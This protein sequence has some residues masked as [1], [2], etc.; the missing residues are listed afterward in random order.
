MQ[1]QKR[2]KPVFAI[3]MLSIS[4]AATVIPS[5]LAF[6]LLIFMIFFAVSYDGSFLS[7]FTGLAIFTA[8]MSIGTVVVAVFII[9]QVA[10]I[11]ACAIMLQ[12]RK[13]KAF[14]AL[15]GII[16]AIKAAD[17]AKNGFSSIAAG[18]SADYGTDIMRGFLYLL[19]AGLYVVCVVYAFKSE[20]L[21][22]YFGEYDM[23]VMPVQ[24]YA[25]PA[26]QYGVPMPP[27][28]PAQQ[29]YYHNGQYPYVPYAPP[30]PTVQQQSMYYAGQQYGAQQGQWAQ[31]PYAAPA[32][33]PSPPIPPQYPQY[34]VPQYPQV[35]AAPQTEED[36]GSNMQ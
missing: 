28:A 31:S 25:P 36:G 4:A 26:G 21:K 20:K 5:L 6:A 18:I 16:Y 9:A 23:L 11:A 35:N 7:D 8:A 19:L 15:F 29:Q 33:P 30:V 14:R 22:I 3:V 1:P 13:A 17:S 34:S 27:S 32:T 12:K 2:E 24:S 10:A